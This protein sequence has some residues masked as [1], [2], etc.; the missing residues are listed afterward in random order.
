VVLSFWNICS[1]SLF[2]VNLAD[3][4]S[5]CMMVGFVQLVWEGSGK[6]L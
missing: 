2:H 5:N 3:F 6:W 4:V 1:Q